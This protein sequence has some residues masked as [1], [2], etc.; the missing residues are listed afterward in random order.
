MESI[1]LIDPGRPARQTS[2][3]EI[4]N[5]FMM[6]ILHLGRPTPDALRSPSVASHADR[7]LPFWVDERMNVGE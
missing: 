1:S 3:S 4:L 6:L 5:L 2:M 7:V